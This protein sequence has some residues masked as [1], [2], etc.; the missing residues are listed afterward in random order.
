MSKAEWEEKR[1]NLA[2][3]LNQEA[4]KIMDQFMEALTTD[5]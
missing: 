4:K 1:G 3:L 5:E 2:V